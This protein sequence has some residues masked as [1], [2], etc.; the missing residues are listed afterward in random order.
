MIYSIKP[1][2]RSGVVSIPASKSYAHRHLICASLCDF[3]SKN[4]NE[5]IALYC[6]GMSKDI[7]AT[8]S[9]LSSLGADIERKDDTIYIK[10]I[11][12]N[13]PKNKENIDNDIDNSS[14]DDFSNAVHL[15]PC[16][17]GSTLRFMLPV[18]GALGVKAVFHMEGKLP[19][20]PLDGLKK[21][22]TKHG[23]TITQKDDL[24]FCSGKL[25]SGEYEI[26]GDVSS[27]YISG[28]LFA[29]PLLNSDSTLKIT[30]NIESLDYIIMTENV[31]KEFGIK[32]EKTSNI[33]TIKG[34]QRYI[35]KKNE[36]V[37][38]D[39]SNAAFFMCI[40]AL[41]DKG[42]TL[43]DMPLNSSQ[44][45]KEIIKILKRFGAKVCIDN[46]NITVKKDKLNGITVDAKSIP[47][48]V[49]TI[50]SLSCFANG[51]TKIINAARLRHKESDRIKTTYEMLKALGADI[52]EL[53]DGL[54]I[55]G[56]SYL[57]GGTV[58]SFNDHR[59]AMSAAVASVLCKND[60]T[61]NGAN[62]VEKSYPDFFRDFEN[63]EVSYE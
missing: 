3:E 32:F 28:L 37:E 12:F 7:L 59:I 10:P 23:M 26:E 25:F 6:K 51:T 14:D 39:W 13:L 22:L 18:V 8:M 11:D 4:E 44:G 1:G 5:R 60:V 48:L 57:L 24:L 42:V 55:N 27:Q 34:N 21:A 40:G 16:E 17:S 61:I 35:G 46:N 63:L 2:Q 36:S 52:K 19:Q 58:D 33:Y 43:T 53:E 30:G 15:H 47:D 49:P 50:C 41:S 62:C 9:C 31:I 29:L 38:K 45:D 56:K 20:R 54:I